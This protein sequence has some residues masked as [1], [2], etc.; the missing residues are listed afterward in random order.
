PVGLITDIYYLNYLPEMFRFHFNA[1]NLIVY[2]KEKDRYL[3]S[4]SILE[5]PVAVD[6]ESLARARFGTGFMSTRGKM[7]HIKNLSAQVDLAPAIKEGIRLASNRIL[8]KPLPWAG[9]KGMHLLAERIKKYPKKLT[10]E[11]NTL[12]LSNIVRM[13]EVVGTGGSGYRFLYA[14]FLKEAGEYL[15]SD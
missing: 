8:N 14:D 4:D 13:Q 11:Q 12:Y 7:Y 9:I 3:I 6:G 10:P 2:G 15:Q 1:H 5:I